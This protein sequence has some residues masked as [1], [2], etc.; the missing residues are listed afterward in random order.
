MTIL[1]VVQLVTKGCGP[2]PVAAWQ[3]EQQQEGSQP[4]DLAE[5]QDSL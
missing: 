2:L 4:L 3:G 1:G 5:S